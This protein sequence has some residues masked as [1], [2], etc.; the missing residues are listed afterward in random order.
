MEILTALMVA[1][2]G[3]LAKISRDTG[4]MRGAFESHV[5]VSNRVQEDHQSRLRSQRA[6]LERHES[7]LQRHEAQLKTLRPG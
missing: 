4:R 5:A 7:A 2:L 1:M 3:L 6:V